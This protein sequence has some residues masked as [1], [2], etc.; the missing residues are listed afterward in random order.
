[1]SLT[2][3]EKFLILAHH[4][5]KPKYAIPEQMRNVGLIGAILMDL[6]NEE[7]IV[8][9]EGRIKV[10]STN[11]RL[12]DPHRAILGKIQQSTRP[13]KV[14]AW[15][16]RFAQLPG[17]YRKAIQVELERKGI[18]RIEKKRFLFIP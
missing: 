11:T 15:I 13:K 6:A 1:M 3:A 10:R 16:S 2:T 17:K 9:E 12:P 5:E 7:R 4:P 18:M 14:K 8:I